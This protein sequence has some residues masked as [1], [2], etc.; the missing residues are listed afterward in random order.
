MPLYTPSEKPKEPAKTQT[1][2]NPQDPAQAK[3]PPEAETKQKNR[4]A[5]TTP[6]PGEEYNRDPKKW[7]RRTSDKLGPILEKIVAVLS[8]DSV[9]KAFSKLAQ[10][11]QVILE[12]ETVRIYLVDRIKKQL[13]TRDF[14]SEALPIIRWDLNKNS[15]PGYVGVTGKSD[16][17]EKKNDREE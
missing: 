11:I 5:D 4:A 13:F 7:G 9:H 14:S 17:I 10:D 3:A 2:E 15:H 12:C 6:D 1:P 8:A 16:F